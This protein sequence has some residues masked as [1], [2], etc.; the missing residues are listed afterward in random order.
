LPTDHWTTI[1]DVDLNGAWWC[2]RSVI[3]SMIE[4]RTGRIIFIGSV[5][6]RRGSL[7]VSVA[8]S[9]AKAGL[10]GLTTGLARQLEQYGI[11]V[12]TIA[13]GPTGTGE[14]MTD[15][16]R[17]TDR[18]NFPLPVMGAAPVAEACRYLVNRSG[19]WISGTIM[20]VSGGRWQG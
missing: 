4:R 16:E 6:G 12:N 18:A 17:A 15:A 2:A 5:A 3:P 20:N 9:A 14:P 13:V 10:F 7:S 11:L 19:D 8:Y 1:I